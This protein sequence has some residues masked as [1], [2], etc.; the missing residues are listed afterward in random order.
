MDNE[1]NLDDDFFYDEEDEEMWEDIMFIK[2]FE[3]PLRN[4][5]EFNY[6]KNIFNQVYTEN[7]DYYNQILRILNEEQQNILKNIFDNVSS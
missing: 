7:R 5:N 3:T 2:K 6:M 1:D 4:V